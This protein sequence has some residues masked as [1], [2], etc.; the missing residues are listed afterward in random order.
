[1]RYAYDFI[2]TDDRVGSRVHP[3]GRL[4]W[5][6]VG[7]RTRDCYGW[8]E[9]VHAAFSGE[10]VDAVDGVAERQWLHP[11]REAW[12][13]LRTT[14][15]FSTT[16]VA[17]DPSRIAGNHVIIRSE[18]L[19]ALYAHLTPGSVAVRSGQL[20]SVGD[21]LGRVGHSGNSTAP[22]LHFQLMDSADVQRAL[23][24]PCAFSDYFVRRRGSLEHV[25]NGIPRARER[26][27]VDP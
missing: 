10:V 16:Q 5:L 22:H 9:P 1:M 12:C 3:A 25:R 27:R 21:V 7:G 11:L 13:A 15:S 23:G 24:V 26:L 8:G 4:Q 17:M 14:L 19:F 6:L 18:R 20:V 2:R